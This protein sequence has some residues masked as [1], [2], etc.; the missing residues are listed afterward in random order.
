M[1]NNTNKMKSKTLFLFSIPSCCCASWHE[2]AGRFS[3]AVPSAGCKLCCHVGC[4]FLLQTTPTNL[5][6]KLFE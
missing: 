1:Y 2:A 3:I 5:R 6:N 4:I